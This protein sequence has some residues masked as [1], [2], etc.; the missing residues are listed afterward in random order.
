MGDVVVEEWCERALIRRKNIEI[1]SEQGFA[2]PPKGQAREQEA[3]GNGFKAIY[4]V[5]ELFFC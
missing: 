1:F 5:S 4:F 3:S 2:L